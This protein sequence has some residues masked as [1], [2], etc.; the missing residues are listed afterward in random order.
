MS[1][2]AEGVESHG[3]IVELVG[4]GSGDLADEVKGLVRSDVPRRRFT[5]SNVAREEELVRVEWCGEGGEALRVEASLVSVA[6]EFRDS[7]RGEGVDAKAVAGGAFVRGPRVAGAGHGS[8]LVED[9]EV[10]RGAVGHDEGGAGRRVDRRVGRSFADDEGVR[11]EAP[12]SKVTDDALVVREPRRGEHEMTAGSGAS[13]RKHRV[14]IVPVDGPPPG[15]DPADLERDAR[16]VQEGKERRPVA[17]RRLQ[18]PRGRQMTRHASRAEDQ[19]PPPECTSPGYDAE[20]YQRVVAA[21]GD[22]DRYLLPTQ[23]NASAHALHKLAL[24]GRS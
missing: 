1:E 4:I 10:A 16:A 7:E 9:V 21:T 3:R 22:S 2:L 20:W 14:D 24:L 19:Q 17:R 6:S 18:R 23:G 11:E 15:A 5:A 13:E 8:H 12:M